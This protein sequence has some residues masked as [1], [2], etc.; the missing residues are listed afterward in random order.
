VLFRIATDRIDNVSP[1]SFSIAIGT[2]GY[3]LAPSASHAH[4]YTLKFSIPAGEPEV[5]GGFCID[6]VRVGATGTW[7]MD[8][9]ASTAPDYFGMVNA[10]TF[11]PDAPSVCFDIVELTYEPGDADGNG[12]VS[13]ADAIFIILYQVGG[14]PEPFPMEA[15]D[16]NCSGSVTIGDVV[17]LVNYIFGGG[18]SPCAI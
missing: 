14:G 13:I 3:A 1:D 17:Y 6:N 5:A 11:E 16:A 15:G 18:P 7:Q 2:S 8:C 9:A 10:G 12:W 4:R